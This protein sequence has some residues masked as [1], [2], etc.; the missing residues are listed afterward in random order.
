MASK[1]KKSLISIVSSKLDCMCG[2]EGHLSDDSDVVVDI[3]KDLSLKEL[4]LLRKALIK[5]ID[6]GFEIEVEV[7]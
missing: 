1:L 2:T 5:K 3:I 4:G 6:N 7:N